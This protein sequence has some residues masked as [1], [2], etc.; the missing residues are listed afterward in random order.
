MLKSEHHSS[1]A[2]IKPGI[3]KSHQLN[4]VEGIRGWLENIVQKEKLGP[5]HHN[6]LK[7]WKIQANLE[8]WRLLQVKEGFEHSESGTF[9]KDKPAS[10]SLDFSVALQ[11]Y[12]D[13]VPHEAST[14]ILP[15]QLTEFAKKCLL[16]PVFGLRVILLQV[17]FLNLIFKRFFVQYIINNKTLK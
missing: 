7:Y 14:K 6:K 2:L 4:P 13:F 10:G 17:L 8:I 11:I 12:K 3:Y 9:H 1:S 5:T 15:G 16:H